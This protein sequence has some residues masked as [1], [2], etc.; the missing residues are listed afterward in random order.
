MIGRL[1]AVVLLAVI[2]VYAVLLERPPDPVPATAP[3]A[4]FSAERAATTVDQ[5]AREPRPVGSPASDVARDAVVARLRAEGLDPR[6][7]PTA[8]LAVEEGQARAARV[9]NVVATLPGT[10]PTGAVVL[11]AHYDSVTA[12][13]GAADDMSGVATLLETVR[14]LRAGPPLR[15]DVTVVITDGEEAG[16]LGARAWVRDQLPRDRPTVVLNWEARGVEG[17]SLLFETSPGNAGLVDAW[18]A[19][20]PHP[21][22]DSSLVEI[23]RFLPNDTDLSPVLDA[24]RPGMNAAFIDRP[25][26]YH[27]PGD[28]PPN[29]SRASLQ[30]HGGNALALT[31]ALGDRDL[32]ALDPTASGQ[33]PTGDRTYFAVLGVLVTYASVWAWAVAGLAL[34]LAVVLVVVARARQRATIGG[35][36]GAALLYV[37]GLVVAVAAGIGL[38][39][40]LVWF[41]PAYADIG[42]FVGR[43]GLYEAAAGVLAF[44]ITTLVVS[45]VRRRP[46]AVALAAGALLVLALLSVALAVVAPGSVFL[47]AWPVVGLALGVIVV[48]FAGERPW[49]AVPVFVLGAVPAVALLIPFAVASYGV[50]GISDGLPVLAFTLVGIPIGAGLSALPR[51]GMARGYALPILAFVWVLILAGGG[52]QLDDPDPRTPYG[53]QLAYVLDAEDGTAR[54]ITTDTAPADWTRGYVGEP[55]AP[56]EAWHGDEPVSRGPA[57]PLPVPPPTAT[58]LSRTPDTLRLQVVSP[59]G[60]PT[61]ILRGDLA[62]RAVTVTY[63]GRPVLSSPLEPGPLTLRLEDVPPEGVLVDLQVTGPVSLRVD[64]QTLGLAG[65][66]GFTPR[67]PDLRQ[68][69]GN[70]SDV[71]VVSRRVAV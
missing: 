53:S 2:G 59:R 38:W 71:V 36:V 58:V 54:W 30:N 42:P 44:V 19:S 6:V 18:A 32:A 63:P 33:P 10:A 35:V 41:R 43:P 11:M 9:D 39:Q 28:V 70:S 60:A 3:P 40:G 4:E 24:G 51:P 29:L 64:D 37:L 45:V 62:A 15:N 12:G 27:T 67:P 55:P 68:A 1:V 31:R 47:L 22:G 61:V 5:L 14:A 21:R 34:V 49:L 20:V 52:L 26:Q 57:T 17:P 65:V 16:L 50:A 25:Y 7:E 48:L 56:L 66:P 13:P 23:Y 69:R 46:G 8:A